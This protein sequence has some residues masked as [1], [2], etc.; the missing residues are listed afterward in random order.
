MLLKVVTGPPTWYDQN[1]ALAVGCRKVE[2]V[3]H[4]FR[5]NQVWDNASRHVESKDEK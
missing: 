4:E 1:G 5:T 3:P 2:P